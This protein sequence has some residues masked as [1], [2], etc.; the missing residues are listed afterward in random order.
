MLAKNSTES[1]FD[2][3]IWLRAGAGAL[4][5]TQGTD[6]PQIARAFRA[7]SRS[8][9]GRRPTVSLNLALLPKVTVTASPPV[10]AIARQPPQALQQLSLGTQRLRA[11]S[12]CRPGLFVH[13]SWAGPSKFWENFGCSLL[14]STSLEPRSVSW[15]VSW[16][17]LTFG[18]AGP[19]THRCLSLFCQP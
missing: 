12:G 14:L 10:F 8:S 16:L 1:L 19:R 18:A 11:V 15:P 2:Q 17:K 13:C 3:R 5:F 6:E 4:L 9:S 7:S